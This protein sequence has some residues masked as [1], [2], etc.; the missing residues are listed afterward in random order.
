MVGST[1]DLFEDSTC[2]LKDGVIGLRLFDIDMSPQSVASVFVSDSTDVILFAL[3]E[4]SKQL[5]QLKVPSVVDE[6]LYSWADRQ[7]DRPDNLTLYT[8]CKVS[9]LSLLQIKY[10]RM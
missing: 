7:T 6:V 4:N 2:L 3:V 10:R 1:C 9:V 8:D 5:F